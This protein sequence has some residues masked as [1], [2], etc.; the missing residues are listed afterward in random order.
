MYCSSVASLILPVLEITRRN[1]RPI[2]VQTVDG[3]RNQVKKIVGPDYT[4]R[5]LLLLFIILL[6]GF[7]SIKQ[8]DYK[9]SAD[10][11]LEGAVKRVIVA[12]F[13]GYIKNA[14]V[15]AGDN[16][17]KDEKLCVLDDRELRL[18]RLNWTS[19]IAQYEKQYQEAQALYKRADAKIIKAQLDQA[20]VRLD[21]TENQLE[22][23]VLTA[24][25][26]GIALSGDLS[27]KLGGTVG[28]GEVLFE[29]APLDEYR[30]ILEV[31]ERR[32]SDVC[33]GQQGWM[34]LSALPNDKISFTIDKITPITT[35]KEGLNYFRVEA[36]PSFVIDRLRPGM[37]GVGKI[38]VDRRNLFTIWTKSMREWFRLKIWEYWP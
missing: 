29:I 28:K 6:L 13:E 23:T 21:L 11:V 20:T 25:F 18:E 19:K 15:R 24:P 12:P 4:G 16:V 37:E 33:I 35:A 3:C 5:K 34:I 14:Y 1:E 26:K 7:F 32:I 17:A 2:L 27:Q 31:D 22:R 36:K 9:I 30:I 8:G 38:Y 10:T